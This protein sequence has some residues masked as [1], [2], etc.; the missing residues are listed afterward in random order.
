MPRQSAGKGQLLEWNADPGDTRF[1]CLAKPPHA[2]GVAVGRWDAVAQGAA[3]P[4]RWGQGRSRGKGIKGTGRSD[5]RGKGSKGDVRG[6]SA[7][8]ASSETATTPSEGDPSP[9][10]AQQPRRARDEIGD[11]VS[12]FLGRVTLIQRSDIDG[13]CMQ[14]LHAIHGLVGQT[15][16]HTAF[17]MMQKA[18]EGKTRSDVKRMPAYIAGLLKHFF[19]E[20]TASAKIERERA[21]AAASA[22]SGG[23]DA[24]S[25][26]TMT[27]AAKVLLEDEE[28]QRSPASSPRFIPATQAPSGNKYEVPDRAHSGQ[29]INPEDN[30]FICCICL[31]LCE[32]PTVLPCSHLFCRG[33]F[34]ELI[35]WS[36]EKRVDKCPACRKPCAHEEVQLDDPQDGKIM[37]ELVENIKVCCAFSSLFRLPNPD[38]DPLPEGHAAR[39]RGLC[40]DWVGTVGQYKHH[41][42][43]C[44]VAVELRRLQ[45]ATM[46]EESANRAD[47]EARRREEDERRTVEAPRREVETCQTGDFMAVESWQPSSGGNWEGT[48]VLH[49]EIGD[50]VFVT[51]VNEQGWAHGRKPD[52]RSGWLPHAMCRRHVFAARIDY[53]SEEDGLLDIHSGDQVVVYKRES[54][55]WTYG[56]K[57]DVGTAASMS[58]KAKGW[59]PSWAIELV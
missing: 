1:Q 37:R 33:C 34:R 28:P 11:E 43:S 41:L 8:A 53:S 27:K 38:D 31:D 36:P 30:Q 19:N 35:G 56:G 14:W 22:S 21:S 45:A 2:E 59:F 51:E 18:I 44:N 55:G 7:S 32:D 40:C 15:G 29:I 12:A 23:S 42:H 13:F 17:Q 48:A 49:L 10:G 52:G 4:G 6:K 58:P 39:E 16:V 9:V 57:L 3:V 5:S 46:A 26:S 25:A 50:R 20:A 24:A 47:D 54:N